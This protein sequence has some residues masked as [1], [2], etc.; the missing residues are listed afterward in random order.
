MAENWFIIHVK[1]PLQNRATITVG[2]KNMRDII[3][4]PKVNLGHLMLINKTLKMRNTNI[5]CSDLSTPMTRSIYQGTV[6]NDTCGTCAVDV[7]FLA[8]CLQFISPCVHQGMHV[9]FPSLSFVCLYTL[10]TLQIFMKQNKI[11][12]DFFWLSFS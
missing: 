8:V 11:L 5:F 4:R 9:I 10:H 6:F 7:D 3:K 12:L 2:K 1:Y